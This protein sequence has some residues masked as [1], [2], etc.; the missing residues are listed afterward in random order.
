MTRQRQSRRSRRC[1]IAAA[2]L[3]CGALVSAS[4]SSS[5]GD[6]ASTQ[7]TTTGDG[8][9]AP[10][11]EAIADA[12]GAPLAPIELADIAGSEPANPDA[13]SWLEIVAAD[14]QSIDELAPTGLGG[15]YVQVD[16]NP[17]RLHLVTDF[18]VQGKVTAMRIIVNTPTGA[19]D[20]EQAVD[21][22]LFSSIFPWTVI[23]V[24]VTDTLGA[25]KT[26]HAPQ[27]GE[28]VTF[29]VLGGSYGV[30]IPA[31]VAARINYLIPAE[32]DESVLVVPDKPTG[33]HVQFSP[34]VSLSIGDELIAFLR[35]GE[36]PLQDNT[37]TQ[38]QLMPVLNDGGGLYR[39]DRNGA[40]SATADKAT[41]TES[42]LIDVLAAAAT[43]I[44][45]VGRDTSLTNS[46]I[47]AMM[48]SS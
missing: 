45:N 34:R 22:H 47:F 27:A 6:P 48:L 41:A 37:T 44:A 33:V 2:V 12:Y 9:P 13:A 25:A 32:D 14:G 42:G 21:D 38:L 23:D 11:S 15:S 30:T 5:A 1:A 46:D 20:V 29:A 7:I 26:V 31:D 24:A 16:A 19:I 40:I 17:E 10:A 18:A 35:T 43:E 39:V 28:T 8:A 36:I 4:C 3:A